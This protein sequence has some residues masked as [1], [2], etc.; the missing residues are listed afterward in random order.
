MKPNI[1]KYIILLFTTVGICQSCE[2]LIEIDSPSNQIDTQNVFEDI[3]T[4][5]AALN[6]LYAELQ[7]YST[8]SGGSSGMGVLLGCYADD[9]DYYYSSSQ[10]AILDIYNNQILSNNS[11]LKTLWSNAY[12]EIYMANAIISG[13]EN[14][15]SIS[16]ENKDQIKGEALLI[17]SLVYYNLQTIFGEIPYTTSTDYLVNQQLLKKST[18]EMLTLLESDLSL[19]LNLMKDNYRN[20]ERIYPNRKVAEL[21]LA[22]VY[23]SE[24]KWSEA[25]NICKIILASPLYTLEND[26]SKEFKKTGKHIMWQLK[27]LNLTEATLEAQ[28]HY[29]SS[30][31]PSFFA[32]SENL[33]SKFDS[34]DLR[35]ELWI[36]PVQGSNKI[37][38]RCKKYQNVSN[39]TNEYSIIY[40]L[41]EVYF[42]LAEALA[43]QN[44]ISE[45]VTYINV[46]KSRAGIPNL[47][48]VITKENLLNELLTESHREFFAEKGMRF[49]NLKLFNRLTDLLPVK[50]NWQIH[51][52]VWPL[53]L[54]EL[55]LNP[56]L[57]PQNAGY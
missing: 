9:L 34:G 49:F 36:A 54:S 56:N 57:N 1:Y 26:L 10:P 41:E 44:K 53:P 28:I 11:A 37:Y 18:S 12:K 5:N 43:S 38:Y 16:Q 2:N 52:T 42:I 6:N 30:T 32:L 13:L 23:L 29:F 47:P 40:R 50:Q 22:Q 20:T 33:I 7:N 25:E 19:S 8:I 35:K 55:L 21:L 17:R 48:D 46:I 24:N 4:A 45:S 39:N 3:T 15:V 51:M 31:T 27:P 14:S